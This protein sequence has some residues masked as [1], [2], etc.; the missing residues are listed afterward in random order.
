MCRAE[1]QYSM[2]LD[3]GFNVVWHTPTATE[4]LG[5]DSLIGRNSIEFIH[6]DD[7]QIVVDT[8]AI[9]T[10]RDANPG[11]APAFRPDPTTLRL[12]MGSGEWLPAEVT[13]YDHTSD[14]EI[15]GYLVTC[16]AVADR[17]D[18]GKAI[19]LLGTGAAVSD[20][21]SLISRLV[22]KT[23]D[24]EAHSTIA[25]WQDNAIEAAWSPDRATN[26]QRM[27]DAAINAVRVGVDQALTIND[28]DDP[29]LVGA[30]VAAREL[31]YSTA[32][33]MPIVS[34]NSS[35]VLGCLLSWGH[36]EV[37]LTMYPQRPI[38]IGLRL[39]AL[40]IVDGRTKNNLRW[41]ASHDPL[42]LLINRAEFA[43]R[44]DA[45]GENVAMLYIDLDDFKPINDVHGHSVGD[46]VL[47]EVAARIRETVGAC[48]IA[49]RLGGDEF[50]VAVG[51]VED[52]Q[53]G[54]DMADRIIE[55][56]RRPIKVGNVMLG[57][58]ASVGV[59]L[60]LQPLIPSVLIQ[61][62]DEALL[63]AKNA[64]KNTVKAAA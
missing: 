12:L 6:P 64:G 42:T 14:P 56:L 26:D 8:M 21:M 20:V 40:A 4:M 58:G 57:V 35:E 39:A 31:G 33:L 32:H 10:A 17:T 45:M 63:D 1:G 41:A 9:L 7:L 54:L 44:L 15:A 62:A 11:T 5:F 52:V 46:A 27:T 53:V 38:H 25:W 47:V 61:R 29:I 16:R 59:A 23:F 3:L 43:R 60:G 28:L 19:E 2:L 24:G 30:G 49:G 37:E 18:I 13:L 51:G 55:A 22:D 36:H 50:A 34:P 48:G